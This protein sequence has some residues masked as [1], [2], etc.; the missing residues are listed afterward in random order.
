MEKERMD[1]SKTK[2]ITTS[3]SEG[4]AGAVEERLAQIR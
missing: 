1:R 2:V 4:V 3:R